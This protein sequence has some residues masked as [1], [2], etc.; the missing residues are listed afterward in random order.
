MTRQKRFTTAAVKYILHY[1]IKKDV[2][3]QVEY[4]ENISYTDGDLYDSIMKIIKRSDQ[5]SPTKLSTA[6]V[7]VHE[8][9]ILFTSIK[10]VAYEITPDYYSQLDRDLSS[11][12]YND[13][14]LFRQQRGYLREGKSYFLEQQQDTADID[15]II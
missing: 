6:F 11:D 4:S 15:I 1:E 5:I 14:K 8:V 12:S 9:G 7:V 3:A 13:E 2:F 10:Y